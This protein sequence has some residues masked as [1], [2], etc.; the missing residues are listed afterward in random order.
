[1]HLGFGKAVLH[2]LP[3]VALFVG[4]FNQKFCHTLSL[5]SGFMPGLFE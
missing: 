4:D 2:L 3:Q 5:G 1:V